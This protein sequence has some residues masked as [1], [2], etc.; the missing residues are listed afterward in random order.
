[1]QCNKKKLE[2]LR[3]C[4]RK[5]KLVSSLPVS[6]R[7]PTSTPLQLLTPPATSAPK[8]LEKCWCSKKQIRSTAKLQTKCWKGGGGSYMIMYL[9]ASLPFCG[10]LHAPLLSCLRRKTKVVATA[11]KTKWVLFFLFIIP[12]IFRTDSISS[13]LESISQCLLRLCDHGWADILLLA[14]RRWPGVL[15]SWGWV[16]L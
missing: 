12:R 1:M 15:A 16:D 4:Q 10:T 7:L 14:H 11:S 6:T 2:T 9:M 13:V 8:E 3:S 5:W